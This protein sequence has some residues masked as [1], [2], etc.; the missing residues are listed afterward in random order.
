MTT[1]ISEDLLARFNKEE[2]KE[3][4]WEKDFL[5]REIAKH[6]GVSRSTIE[7]VMRIFGI[8]TRTK[9]EALRLAYASGKAKINRPRGSNSPHWRGGRRMN[10]EYVYIYK[11][12]HPRATKAGTVLES[13]LNWEKAN[14]QEVPKGWIVHHINGIKSDN[15]PK[16][17]IA[18]P[19]RKH[20]S[21]MYIQALQARIRE[22]E[23][24]NYVKRR[25]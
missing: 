24:L 1:Q 10:G 11:P 18:M 21:W 14:N 17:L 3:L 19:K 5:Q 25:F 9:S 20:N 6:Y 7:E 4:Y 16:N 22:L 12:E 13:V 8:R 2:I 23:E 15:R